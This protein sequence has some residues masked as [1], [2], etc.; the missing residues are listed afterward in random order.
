MKTEN[1]IRI[2]P[3]ESPEERIITVNGSPVG[4]TLHIRDAK[5]V[6]NWLNSAKKQFK[7]ILK[8]NWNIFLFLL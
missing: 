8:W 5:I 6:E 7:D 4:W 2:E 3:W 1:I